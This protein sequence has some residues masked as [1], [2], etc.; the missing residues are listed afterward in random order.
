VATA[1]RDG[2]TLAYE[3]RGSGEPPLVFVP[4]WCCDRTFFAPQAEHF[5]ARHAVTTLELRGCGESGRPEHGYDVPTQADDVAWLCRELGIEQPVVI[6]HSLGGM[7]AIELAARHPMLPRAVVAVDPGPIV[8]PPDVLQV[9]ADFAAAL[10]L[11]DAEETRRAFVE[12]MFLPTDDP[13]L[14]ARIVEAM[15]SVPADTAAAVIRGVVEWDGRTALERCAVPTLVIRD[16]PGDSDTPSRLVAVKPDVQ[17]GMTVGSG[18]FIQL[19]VPEQVT[20]MIE[21][22]LRVAVSPRRAP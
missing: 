15:C 18:H 13:E 1:S 5:S 11:P 16:S 21:R 6:G 7:I 20:P 19:E 17:V 9:Y 4:G 22:F 14:K 8:A 12:G 2:L 10:E 3:Q